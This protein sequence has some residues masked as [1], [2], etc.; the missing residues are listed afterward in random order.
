MGKIRFKRVL[1]S[2]VCILFLIAGIN[3]FL[4]F[5]GWYDEKVKGIYGSIFNPESTENTADKQKSCNV[6]D[7][8]YIFDGMDMGYT[9]SFHIKSGMV[10]LDILNVDDVKMIFDGMEQPVVARYEMKQSDTAYWDLSS[11]EMGHRYALAVYGSEDAEF[12]GE[13]EQQY[14]IKRWQHIYNRFMGMLDRTPKYVPDNG[15]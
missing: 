8:F 15:M 3:L 14:F 4:Y 6:Y 13:I 10:E 1:R 2:V 7:Y 9:V 11:L 12:I 5:I